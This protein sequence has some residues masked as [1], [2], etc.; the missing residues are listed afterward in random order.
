MSQAN[1]ISGQSRRPVLLATQ[2]QQAWPKVSIIICA[3]NRLADLKLNLSHLGHLR[4][5]HQEVVL[6]DDASTDGTYEYLRALENVRVVRSDSHIGACRARNRGLAETRADYVVFLDADDK[7]SGD[8]LAGSV[9]IAER[10]KADIVFLPMIVRM[11]DRIT[12]LTNPVVEHM[13]PE[14]LLVKWLLGFQVNPSATFWR[15]SFIL[16]FGGWNNDLLIQQDGEVVLRALLSRPLEV[17]AALSRSYRDLAVFSPGFGDWG[18]TTPRTARPGASADKGA[19][20]RP[21]RPEGKGAAL[22]F[23]AAASSSAF[24]RASSSAFAFAAA[25]S[26]AFF[27]AA[28]SSSAESFFTSI[29]PFHQWG[30]ARVER[31]P[32]SSVQISS[33]SSVTLRP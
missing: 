6:V 13:S 7:I 28:A 4:Y 14:E 10:D 15:R 18:G 32:R 26:S 22:W 5:P 31:W 33:P 9:A 11:S 3:R 21:S 29:L 30:V 1:T 20:P 27:N 24:N 19:A 16:E 12:R 8:H 25:S 2:H 23:S 17:L